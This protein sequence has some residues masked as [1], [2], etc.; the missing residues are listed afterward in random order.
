MTGIIGGSD[1]G[2]LAT[3]SIQLIL[4]LNLAH[5]PLLKSDLRIY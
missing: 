5:T 2:H 1:S 3:H 4:I